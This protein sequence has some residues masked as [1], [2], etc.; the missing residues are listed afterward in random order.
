MDV[1]EKIQAFEEQTKL[2]FNK[3]YNNKPDK[4]KELKNGKRLL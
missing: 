3:I 1:Y 4:N 2:E